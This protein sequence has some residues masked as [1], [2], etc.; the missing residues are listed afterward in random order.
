M[1]LAEQPGKAA[2]Q[3]VSSEAEEEEEA[4]AV[5]GPGVGSGLGDPMAVAVLQLTNLVTEMEKKVK[6]RQGIG[7]PSRS[8]RV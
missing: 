5:G 3:E 6:E 7:G 4:E 8:S 1:G 2:P